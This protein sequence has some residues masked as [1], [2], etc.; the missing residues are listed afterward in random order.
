[1]LF[2]SILILSWV[3]FFP[4]PQRDRNNEALVQMHLLL[5][6]RRPFLL[7]FL[8]RSTAIYMKAMPCHFSIHKI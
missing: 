4:S 8:L 5:A 2:P 3:C 7:S 1:L 6:H